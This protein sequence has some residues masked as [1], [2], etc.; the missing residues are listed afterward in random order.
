MQIEING[1]IH[2]VKDIWDFIEKLP[3]EIQE[4]VT[5]LVN[6]EIWK[7]EEAFIPML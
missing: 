1:E 5:L 6:E 4:D 3:V 2:F 7:V